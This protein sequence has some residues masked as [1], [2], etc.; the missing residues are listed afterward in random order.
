MGT[1]ALAFWVGPR[2]RDLAERHDFFTVGDLL[3]HRYGALVRAVMTALLWIATPAILAGQLIALAVVLEV[4]I[5]LPRAAGLILGGLV[6]T[7]Y[8]TAG[9]LRG[10]AWINLLQL[11]ALLVGLVVALP[12]AIR[13]VGGMPGLIEAAARVDEGYLDFWQNGESG[14]LLLAILAPNFIVSPG[15][16]QKVYGA[17]DRRSVHLGLGLAALALALFAFVPA[18]L[19]MVARVARPDL[20]NPDHALPLLLQSEVPLVIGALGLGALFVADI[21]SADAILFMLA[22]SMSK[23]LFKRFLHPDASDRQVLMVARLAAVA[24]GILAVIM[25]L[26]SS[27]VVGPLQVFY[28][29]VGLSLFVPVIAALYLRRAGA[30]EVLFALAGGMAAAVSVRLAFGPAGLGLLTPNLS[31]ILAAAGGFTVVWAARRRRSS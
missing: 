13:E 16:L 21:S 28:S 18:V 24:G 5:D 3:E 1:A 29:L 10:S 9:G 17:R 4:V 22:T 7:T 12:L 30:P 31:G 2:V 25:G 19:G 20:V 27:S 14:W 6:T 8:F 26:F 15:L 23:D 11:V